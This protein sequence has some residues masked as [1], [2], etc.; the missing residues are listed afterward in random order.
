MFRLAPLSLTLTVLACAGTDDVA[1]QSATDDHA[2]EAAHT[3]GDDLDPSTSSSTT[4]TSTSSQTSSS[5]TSTSSGTDDDDD[6]DDDSTD[7]DTG[8]SCP[9][10]T[11]GCPCDDDACADDLVCVHDQCETPLQCP[12]DINEPNDSEETAV[13]LG[14]INDCNW[15]GGSVDGVLSWGDEDWFT[16]TGTDAF[17]CWVDP[18]REIVADADIRICKFAECLNGLENTE[19]TCPP[20]TKSA[21]SPAGRPGCCGTSDFQL[22]VYDCAG[23]INDSANVYI[24]IDQGGEQ[25]VEYTFNY[26]Y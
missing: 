8:A 17:G 26:H 19:L 11:Q 4:T 21:T 2:T 20:P 10:G 9:A 7:D 22:S 1:A 6:D 5:S 14:Q 3:D 12:A 25:C 23:T 15:N 24:R 16:Y 18:A 13:F